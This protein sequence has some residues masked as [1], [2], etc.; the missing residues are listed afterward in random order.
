MTVRFLVDEDDLALGKAL[1]DL[2]GNVVFPGH[3]DIPEVSEA[4][5]SETTYDQSSRIWFGCEVITL[6]AG[7]SDGLYQVRK[8]KRS[9]LI[10]GEQL[11]G[12]RALGSWR[13]TVYETDAGDVAVSGTRKETTVI[14]PGV[15]RVM[16]PLSWPISVPSLRREVFGTL[17]DTAVRLCRPR[18]GML[19]RHRS[20]HIDAGEISLRTEYQR[21]RRYRIVRPRDKSVV[22]ERRG[23][24]LFLG[25]DNSPSEIALA[26]A[27]ERAGLIRTSSLLNYLS[28]SAP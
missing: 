23:I 19:R 5:L 16:L 4:H 2:H 25:R 3:P 18:Y 26:M 28:V 1:A 22:L 27:V 10:R 21:M 8:K 13:T 14:G 12:T 9:S 6:N 11:P 17:G 15:L 7:D 24:K 20:I